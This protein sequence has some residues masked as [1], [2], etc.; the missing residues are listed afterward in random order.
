[1]I[2]S[3]KDEVD[4]VGADYDRIQSLLENV[5]YLTTDNNVRRKRSLLPFVG[6]ALSFLFGT[7][8]E[9]DLNVIRN[10]VNTLSRNQ[11]RISHVVQ[12]SLTIVKQNSGLIAENRQS[13][14]HF[15]TDL[16]LLHTR[17]NN[18]T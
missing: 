2:D 15:I 1:M 6:S 7:V 11:Q 17:L 12:K 5:K 8:S 14:N 4:N 13:I 10:Q 18:V 16:S 9:G 3:I